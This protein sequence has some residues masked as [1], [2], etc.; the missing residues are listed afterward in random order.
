M[1]LKLIIMSATLRVDDFANNIK[2]FPTIGGGLSDCMKA[3]YEDDVAEDECPGIRP[4][5]PPVVN[6]ESRQFPVTCHFAR[7]TPE[8]YMKATLKKVCLN[9]F[10]SIYYMQNNLLTPLWLL[11]PWNSPHVADGYSLESRELRVLLS[12]INV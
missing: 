11:F 5:A 12:T 7:Y 10:Q 8:D 4:G 9:A 3:P 1:P 2:L 6:I